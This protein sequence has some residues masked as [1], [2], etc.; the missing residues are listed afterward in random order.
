[1]VCDELQVIHRV[2]EVAVPSKDKLPG[3]IDTLIAAVRAGELDD[4]FAQASKQRL[5]R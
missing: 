3:I 1:M 2:V 5:I 4:L